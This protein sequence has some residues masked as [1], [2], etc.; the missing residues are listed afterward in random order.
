MYHSENAMRFAGGSTILD[1]KS[2]STQTE[3]KGQAPFY[4]RLKKVIAVTGH[5][6]PYV[7]YKHMVTLTWLSSIALRKPRWDE[8]QVGMRGQKP[9]QNI[10]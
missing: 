9:L 3:A 7:L 8:F 4:S 6:F 1:N 5:V 10:C 2:R